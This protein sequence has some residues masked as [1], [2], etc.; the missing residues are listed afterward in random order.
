MLFKKGVSN[1]GLQD[2]IGSEAIYFQV[3]DDNTGRI[4][5]SY[6]ES[7]G[8]PTIGIGHLIRSNERE[9]FSQFLG[10]RKEMTRKQVF[11][12]FRKDVQAH[13]DPW[14]GTIKKPVTQEMIDALA[15][16]AFNVG[17]NSRTLKNAIEAI[18]RKDYQAASDIIRDGPTTNAATG[19]VMQGL[20][21]RRNREADLFLSGGLP[22]LVPQI[23]LV[24]SLVILIGAFAYKQ[25]SK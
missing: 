1:K 21:K 20:V 3:Y 18:N 19:Q 17:V 2:L 10:G 5:S 11:D 9:Y 25:V 14:I 12:L 15:S 23:V 16:L 22:S 13:V 8:G 4:I 6:E 7:I 24:S